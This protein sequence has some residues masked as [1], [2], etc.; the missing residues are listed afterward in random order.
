MLPWMT[1]DRKTSLALFCLDVAAVAVVFNVVGYL[2]G[3]VDQFVFT[4]LLVP[5]AAIAIAFQLIDGY[6]ART[7][8]MSLDYASLHVIAVA[9]SLLATLLL[10]YAF[11][12]GGFELQSSRA[13]IAVSFAALLPVSLGYRRIVGQRVAAERRDRCLVFIGDGPSATAFRDECARMG[14]VETIVFAAFDPA[15]PPPL[16]SSEP[17]RH[18]LE[19]VLGDIE[20]GRLPVDAIIFR[21]SSARLRP[22]AAERLVRLHFAGVPTYTLE[23]FHQIAWRKIPIYRLDP[24]WLFQEGFSIAREPVFE[25]I[26]RAS[27][28]AFAAVGLV[29]AAPVIGLAAL[30]IVLEDRGPVFYS[31]MRIGWHGVPFR[32]AKLRTMKLGAGGDLYTWPGDSRITRVGRFLRLTRLD[33]LPQL[34]NVLRGQ[35]SLIGPR[36]EWDKLAAKY[37]RQIPCY[38]FRHLVKPGI[39]GWAQVNYLYGSSL[40]DTVRKLE[41]DLYYI[42]HFSFTLDASIV[43]KTIQVMLFG[44]GR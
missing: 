17:P 2:R 25:R 6:R 37:E 20:G 3:V 9:C 10:T 42:R 32:I 38:N 5:I 35:M 41:Y 26:K 12:P 36:A 8:M 14:A 19:S 16:D 11:A 34:W 29:L 27:D 44:K 28:I 13:V 18:P 1:S 39:T 21:E 15:E 22:E 23:L 30:A 4:P 40:E 24:A 7:D 33:E 43:L 31:Q